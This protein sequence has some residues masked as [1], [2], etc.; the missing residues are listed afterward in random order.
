MYMGVF[1][2]W[3]LTVTLIVT[4]IMRRFHV[5]QA[6]RF[7][8]TILFV[9]NGTGLHWFFTFV[10]YCGFYEITLVLVSENFWT[11]DGFGINRWY[12]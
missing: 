12:F 7:L 5:W 10:A 6:M 8:N 4:E 11:K 9:D 1:I 3:K 2:V